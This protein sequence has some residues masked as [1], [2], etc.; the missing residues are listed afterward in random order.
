MHWKIKQDVRV[1]NDSVQSF[2]E[3]REGASIQ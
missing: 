2:L 1:E 3:Y